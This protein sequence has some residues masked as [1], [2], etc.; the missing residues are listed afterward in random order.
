MKRSAFTLLEVLLVL[1]VLGIMATLSWPRM[2]A[3]LKQQTLHGNVEQVRQVLDRARVRA[4]EQ[5]R[6]LQVRFEPRGKRYVVLPHDPPE[7]DATGSSSGGTTTQPVD[8]AVKSEPFR[9][10][11][12]AESCFFHVDNALLSGESIHAERLDDPWLSELD[13]GAEARDVAWARPVLFH[14][15]GSAT[16]GTFV[17][18]DQSNRYVKLRVRGLTGSVSVGSMAVLSDKLGS[19]GN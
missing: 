4:V 16:D 11:T 2:L 6:T 19:T 18:M 17:V 15:D 1:S 3:Q 8:S 9:V 13:N 10:Y 12:L 5:G 7:V 14:P